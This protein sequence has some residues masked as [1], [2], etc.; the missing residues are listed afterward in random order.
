MIDPKNIPQDELPLIALSDNSSG[1]LEFLIK[2]RTKGD[3]NHIMW[4]HRTGFFASQGNTYSEARAERYLKRGSRLK[5]YTIAGLNDIQKKLIVS[6]IDNK[7]NSVWWKKM[8][9]WVGILG[10]AI[11]IKKINTPGLNYC[12]EDV[13]HH[14]KFMAR[15]LAEGDTRK[16]IILSIPNHAS[17]QELNDYF[18]D[19]PACFVLWGKWEADDV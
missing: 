15:H 11:G 18:K 17:P 19:N 14:L 16:S 3:Y 7:L 9:D 4:A 8:Y 5:F 10:Q 12:S 6:S 1:L 2:F 13:P